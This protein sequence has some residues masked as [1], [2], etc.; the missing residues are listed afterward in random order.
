MRPNPGPGSRPDH[1]YRY[2]G[3]GSARSEGTR[4]LPRGARELMLALDDVHISYGHVPALRGVSLEISEGEIVG[5][6]GA[7]GAG[8]TT[9]LSAIFGLVPL[10]KGTIHF[11]GDSLIG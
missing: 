4:R 3:G 6:L 8:K 1:L 9:L 7:N 5:L 11:E 10:R 2:P